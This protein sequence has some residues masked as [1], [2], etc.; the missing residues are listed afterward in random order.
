VATLESLQPAGSA[1]PTRRAALFAA[2]LTALLAGCGGAERE[3]AVVPGDENILGDPNAPVTVIEYASVTCPGCKAFH[4][5][6]F[7]E[8]KARYVDT[9]KVCF[10]FRELP[11][12]PSALSMA[13][14]LMAR[15][16]PEDKYFDV[17]N[18]LFENQ[19]DLIAAYQAGG[20]A[21]REALL[22]IA[23][24]VGITE[25]EFDACIRND[26]EITR[27]REVGDAGYREFGV[28]HTPTFVIDGKTYGGMSLEELAAII[29]PLLAEG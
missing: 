11:T 5:L 14:M 3:G 17:L 7:P 24:P 25:E 12:S 28:A 23:R 10:I 26:A 15:C 9:G 20:G 22:A 1:S 2:G 4:D 19:R 16:A 6:V 18:V 21:A 13:G 29:D 8:F 27:M